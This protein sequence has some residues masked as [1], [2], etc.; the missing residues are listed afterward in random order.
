[1]VLLP[2]GADLLPGFDRWPAGPV[3]DAEGKVIYFTA[4]DAGRRPVF[5]VEV[6]TGE[7]TKKTSD[8]AHYTNLSAAPDGTA[9]YALRDAIDEPPAPVRIDLATGEVA[10]LDAPGAVAGVPGRVASATRPA[11]FLPATTSRASR[12]SATRLCAWLPR[13]LGQ[14][15]EVVPLKR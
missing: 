6:A 11:Q 13:A 8:D 9:L 2:G 3:W 1:M 5:A 4:D 15:A 14:T 10:R 7:V 12:I